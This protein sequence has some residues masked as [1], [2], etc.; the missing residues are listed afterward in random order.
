ME[1]RKNPEYV[2]D[3]IVDLMNQYKMRYAALNPGSSFRALHDSI[4]NY[5]GN[6]KPKIILCCHEEI[7]IAIA[8]GYSKASREPM[9]AICHN[10]V[11]LQHA[12]M[13]IYNAWVDRVPVIVLGATGPSDPTGKEPFPRLAPLHT[14]HVQGQLVRDYVKWDYQPN[15]LPG[16]LESF[17]RA[18]KI[19]L[20]EPMGPVYVCYDAKLQEDRVHE[21]P[22]MEPPHQ[23]LPSSSP[24]GD[25]QK[26]REVVERILQARNPV[27]ITGM[28]GRQKDTWRSVVSFAELFGLPVIDQG[29]RF[30]IPNTHP[31]TVTGAEKEALQQADLVIALDVLDLYWALTRLSNRHEPLLNPNAKIIRIGLEDF[32][33]RSWGET[34]RLVPTDLSITADTSIALPEMEKH[35]S[36]I[37]ARGADT[38]KQIEERAA[39]IPL[40]HQEIRDRWIREAER[41]WDDKP[42]SLPRLLLELKD[43]LASH[44][45]SLV[46]TGIGTSVWARRLWDIEEPEQFSGGNPGG[47]LGYGIGASIGA[48]LTDQLSGRICV[49]LQA[50]GDLLYTL[51]GLWTASHLKIPLLIVMTNNRSYYN[52]EEHAENMALRRKRP[53]ENKTIGF[54]IESPAVDFAKIARGFHIHAEGPIEDPKEISGALERAVKVVRDRR[55]PALVDVIT[56]PR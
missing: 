32:T 37:I 23:Y 52:D 17:A 24:S 21:M 39:A 6:E 28:V 29:L 46:N 55:L 36:Q 35:A 25:P 54:R 26:L 48:A 42:A 33:I 1:S 44:P 27:L 20:T 16:V 30:N 13:A 19:A 14:A 3:L 22:L 53:V 49:D 31:L 18:Y 9:V 50:D 45:W 11:G 5:G 7:A 47:G 8:H 56:Q 41:Q 38:R 51:S 4:V 34:R 43:L 2:S 12:S 15:S 10:V 40:R